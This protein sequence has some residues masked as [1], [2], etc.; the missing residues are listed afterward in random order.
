MIGYVLLIS[1]AVV[2]AGLVYHWA[3]TY[4][5]RE[6]VKCQEGVSIFIK[7]IECTKNS[8][9][10][11]L[12]ISLRNNG[13]FS[14][15]AFLM[16][17]T[18]NSQEKVATTELTGNLSSSVRYISNT[19]Y[20]WLKPGVKFPGKSNSFNPQQEKSNITFAIPKTAITDIKL[21]E[22]TPMRWQ[23]VNNKQKLITCGNAKIREKIE[24]S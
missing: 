17:G 14:I 5:P 8:T 19:N 22:I 12:N 23:E 9:H 20:L 21:I 2:M 13:R 1:F 11:L 3:K 16:H 6:E 18:N 15:G 4:I 10:F 7:K 24:C